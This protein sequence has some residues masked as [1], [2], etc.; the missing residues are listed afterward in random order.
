MTTN[1]HPLS[2]DL[3]RFTLEALSKLSGW[4]GLA[5]SDVLTFERW[6]RSPALTREP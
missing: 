1:R 3:A 5:V 2:A 6:M 4:E